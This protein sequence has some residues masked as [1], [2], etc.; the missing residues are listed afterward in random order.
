MI[1]KHYACVYVLEILTSFV[2]R[3]H[4]I[5]LK[6]KQFMESQ[7]LYSDLKLISVPKK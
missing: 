2:Y 7:K 4:F 1:Q 3:R 5:A 6:E